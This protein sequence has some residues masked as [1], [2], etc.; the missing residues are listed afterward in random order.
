MSK[1]MSLKL[2]DLKGAVV[3]GLIMA[4][5][6]MSMHILGVGNIYAVN[7]QDL[8]NVGVLALLTSFVSLIKSFFTNEE[9]NFLG[10]VKVK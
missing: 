6:A 3:S 5:F 9:G 2:K 8:I 4:L 10:V 7:I 1:I